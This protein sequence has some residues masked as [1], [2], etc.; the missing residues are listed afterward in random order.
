MRLLRPGNELPGVVV[1]VLLG[2]EDAP[3]RIVV[4]SP[5]APVA[6][7]GRE[8]VRILGAEETADRRIAVGDVDARELVVTFVRE[9]RGVL[10]EERR[11]DRRRRVTALR[12]EAHRRRGAGIGVVHIGVDRPAGVQGGGSTPLPWLWNVSPRSSTTAMVRS[13]SHW[14]LSRAACCGSP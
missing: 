13:V 12:E 14:M 1:A 6:V 2:E 4:V 7:D 3:W 8:G 10:V 11:V 9:A 5:S